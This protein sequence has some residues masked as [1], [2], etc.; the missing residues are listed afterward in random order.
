M[1]SQI[2]HW[3]QTAL[4]S[5]AIGIGSWTTPATGPITPPDETISWVFP[6]ANTQDHLQNNSGTLQPVR[7]AVAASKEIQAVLRLVEGI[8]PLLETPAVKNYLNELEATL[9]SIEGRE[10]GAILPS[11]I[12]S[13]HQSRSALLEEIED[14]QTWLKIAHAVEP[15]ASLHIPERFTISPSEWLYSSWQKARGAH[16]EATWN[17]LPDDIIES[18]QSSSKKVVHSD[19]EFLGTIANEV[20]IR[21]PAEISAAIRL[22][23]GLVDEGLAKKSEARPYLIRLLSSDQAA[24]RTAVVEALW[25]AQD[26][27]AVK[28]LQTALEGESHPNTRRTLEHVLRILS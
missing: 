15:G 16:R 21:S 24:V 14:A 27:E 8:E 5:L 7:D 2:Y 3:L 17:S 19:L 26:R 13:L 28:A 10:L 22:L 18:L 4:V 6:S 1:I 25:L 9:K 11:L 20:E 12:A 23:G